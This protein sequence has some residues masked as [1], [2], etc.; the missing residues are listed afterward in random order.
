MC[1]AARQQKL[2]ASVIYIQSFSTARV[3]P[4]AA[5]GLKEVRTTP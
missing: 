4:Q 1:Q 3:L 5:L 2:P